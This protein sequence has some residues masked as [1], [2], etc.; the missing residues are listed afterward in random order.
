MFTHLP[1]RA[2]RV[3]SPVYNV[4]STWS[5]MGF[6]SNQPFLQPGSLPSFQA[7][8]SKT[9]SGHAECPQFTFFDAGMNVFTGGEN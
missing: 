3:A 2:A 4:R 8:T 7:N 6:L 5:C 9:I 1:H